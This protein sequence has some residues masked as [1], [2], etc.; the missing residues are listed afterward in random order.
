[1]AKPKF[2]VMGWAHPNPGIQVP[3]YKACPYCDST[4]IHYI[5][6][7][8]HVDSSGNYFNQDEHIFPG[9]PTYF[10]WRCFTCNR[11]FESWKFLPEASGFDGEL[12]G[13]QRANF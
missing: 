11:S 7:S 12:Q 10:S 2:K 3:G 6:S 13:E 8:L 5:T 1:M 9:F 4:D